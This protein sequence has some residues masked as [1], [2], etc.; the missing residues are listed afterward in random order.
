M[1]RGTDAGGE[2]V[3]GPTLRTGLPSACKDQANT[4]GASSGPNMSWMRFSQCEGNK[5]R[6][7]I[8]TSNTNLCEGPGRGKNHKRVCN[9]HPTFPVTPAYIPLSLHCP[10]FNGPSSKSP[11]RRTE[12][13]KT[14]AF[15]EIKENTRRG[16]GD[17][18]LTRGLASPGFPCGEQ[19]LKQTVK[20]TGPPSL[21]SRRAV[22]HVLPPTGRWAEPCSQTSPR[23]AQPFQMRCLESE[24]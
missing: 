24:A 20:T 22:E 11:L 17:T 7:N 9:S 16:V 8:T 15:V 5:I 19:G 10:Q 13:W 18:M 4:T 2:W 1:W 23:S 3:T 6:D 14:R 21:R 12:H